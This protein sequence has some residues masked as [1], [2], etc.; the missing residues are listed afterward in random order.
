VRGPNFGHYEILGANKLNPKLIDFGLGIQGASRLDCT[1]IEFSPSNSPAMAYI[2]RLTS[3]NTTDRHTM[4]I[5][6][7]FG[8][9]GILRIAFID[10]TGNYSNVTI[11]NFPKGS[12]STSGESAYEAGLD[13]ISVD[14]Q[15]ELLGITQKSQLIDKALSADF[16]ALGD[17]KSAIASAEELAKIQ[18]DAA[19]AKAVAKAQS[20]AEKAAIVAK[21]QAGAE[22]TNALTKAQVD[23]ELAKENALAKAKADAELAIVKA[24]VEAKADAELAIVNALAEAKADADALADT[25][26]KAIAELKVELTAYKKL[27]TKKTTITCVKG[28]L[29]LQKT[30]TPPKCPAG[31]TKKK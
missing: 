12:L 20:D 22:L 6:A 1:Y 9:G 8:T 18:S 28:K 27:T 23:A 16:L 17:L 24:L 4:S 30:G 13:R 10:K 21:T 3:R 14:M 5:P 26:A 7:D 31:W 2:A 15:P 11:Y 25:Q 19:L 29:A